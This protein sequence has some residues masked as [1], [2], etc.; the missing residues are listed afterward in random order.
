[1]IKPYIMDLESTN[2]TMINKTKI[3]PA[4]YYELKHYDILNFGLSTIDY[5]VIKEELEKK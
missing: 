2:G 5:V 1:M 4:R 3:E